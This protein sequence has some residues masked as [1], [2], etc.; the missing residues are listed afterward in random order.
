VIRVRLGDD[1]REIAR[2]VIVKDL[3]AGKNKKE[4]ESNQ[5]ALLIHNDELYVSIGASCPACEESDSRRATIMVYNLDGSNERVFARGLYQ[6][7]GMA[8][9]P[10]TGEL[11]ASNQ[12]RPQL[13]G[14]APE[15]LYALQNSD[16]AGWAGCIA[17]EIIAPE[18]GG[19]TACEGVVQPL[20]KFAPQGNVTGILFYDDPHAPEDYQGDLLVILNGGVNEAG[21]QVGMGIL[22]LDVDPQIGVLVGG[23]PQSFVTGFWLSEEP[24]DYLG[25]PYDLTMTND[26]IIFIT[27]DA[28]GAVYELRRKS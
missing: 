4:V 16:N 22:R 11:W 1:W 14:D 6:V 8:I 3:P 19:E 15:T 9:N 10:V 20:A 2:E 23:E 28:A 26:G 7:L 13:P 5:H 25:R 24:G 18:I 27:D 12:G 21:R 17:G